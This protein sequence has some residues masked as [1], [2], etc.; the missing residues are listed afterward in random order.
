MNMYD[1]LNIDQLCMPVLEKLK[2]VTGETAIL[3]Y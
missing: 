3:P 1:S 2:D